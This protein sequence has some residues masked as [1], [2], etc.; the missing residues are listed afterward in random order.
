MVTIPYVCPFGDVMG[1]IFCLIKDYVTNLSVFNCE[2]KDRK[3]KKKSM[4]WMI[5][6]I[7][8]SLRTEEELEFNI[9]FDIL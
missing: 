7:I 5:K 1:K 9:W 2:F 8:E 4:I 6:R 3:K